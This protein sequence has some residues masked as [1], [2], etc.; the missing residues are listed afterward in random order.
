MPVH[1]GWSGG[2]W[3]SL[4]TT[5][6][7]AAIAAPLT[8][9]LGLLAAWV[10]SRQRFAG[11]GLLEFALML[12]FCVPGTVIGV[13]YILTFNIPPVEIT[14]TAIILVICFIFRN[15]PVGVRSGMAAMSQLDK[16]LDEASTTLG[17]STFA[18]VTKVLLPLLK[19][20]IVTALVY[21]F[22]RAMTTVSAVIFL[23]S[24]QYEMATVFI[25]NRAIN[26]DYGIA[27]A[28]STVLIVLM[29]AA[30][31]FIQLVVGERRLGRRTRDADTGTQPAAV[32]TAGAKS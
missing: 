8:A 18:T 27:I 31:G 11:R 12:T 14:G 3:S 7:L 30:I 25:I 19:P 1:P 26:G 32:Q 16:S 13:G 9:A 5:L 20:A 15:L 4:F 10:F 29:M 28:Y 22:V 6:E 2:A 24:A 17:A 21:A 23:T